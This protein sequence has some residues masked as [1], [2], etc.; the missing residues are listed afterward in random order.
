MD[1]RLRGVQLTMALGLTPAHGNRVR[2]TRTVDGRDFRHTATFTTLPG[3][4]D[5]YSWMGLRI[6]LRIVRSR[7]RQEVLRPK[8]TT[9]DRPSWRSLPLL[10]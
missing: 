5:L 3:W 1:G 4:R 8:R 9:E 6:I 7:D 10:V 2:A